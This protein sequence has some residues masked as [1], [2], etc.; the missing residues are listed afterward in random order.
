[1]SLVCLA[2]TTALAQPA[3]P[4]PH[5]GV[6]LQEQFLQA[7][8]PQR[9]RKRQQL[10][11]LVN[12]Q[13]REKA[14][15]G[16][17][18]AEDV[19]QIPV[20]VHVVHS[21]ESGF[22]GGAGNTNISDEQIASQIQVLNEDYRRKSNTRGYNT[23][24]AGA[25]AGIEFYLARTD[26]NGNE[27]SG[28]TRTYYAARSSFNVFS[29][30]TD[31]LLLS[32]IAYWPSDRYLNIWVTTLG[33]GNVIGVAQY[34]EASNFPGLNP[35][36]NAATD[37]V[38]IDYRA[39]GLITSG[40]RYVHNTYGRTATHEIGHWLGL[41]H[42]W[43]DAV[44]GDDYCADTPPAEGSND[45]GTCNAI[46]SNCS[47]AQ[48]RNLIEDYMDYS[49]DECMNIF[50][51]DQKARMRAV[52]EVSPRRQT[53]IRS[54]GTLPTV[55]ALAVS[56]SPNPAQSQTTLEVLL[57]GTQNFK[58]DIIDVAG[59]PVRTQQYRNYTSSLLALST[60][61]LPTGV[62][63]VKVST[64]TESVARRLVVY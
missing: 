2:L 46:Y 11:T 20:V 24:P 37:G 1:M 5:C 3:V 47:G 59:R 12:N 6:A 54:A 31:K 9:L 34:P 26:P 8:D 28:I 56:L 41:F 4:G 45:T 17:R 58:I 43:G 7:R 39:F 55:Q 19:Y 42:T 63:I 64:D 22:V 32:Q 49:P 23:N 48:T 36:E 21:N 13:I 16:A 29:T 10:E 27:T 44:C 25:D 51:S 35:A 18:V 60:E 15:Q 50:T 53:L 57:P 40:A 61:T 52:L 38:F 14:K 62:Y 30:E 33:D